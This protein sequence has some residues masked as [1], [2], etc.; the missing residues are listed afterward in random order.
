MYSSPKNQWVGAP[1]EEGGSANPVRE[2]KLSYRVSFI[3]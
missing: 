3:S 2:P 1:T